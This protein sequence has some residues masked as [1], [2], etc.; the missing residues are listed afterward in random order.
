MQSEVNSGTSGAKQ[1]V[2]VMGAE[3]PEG[4]HYFQPTRNSPELGAWLN[5]QRWQGTKGGVT[6]EEARQALQPQSPE[7]KGREDKASGWA[8]V[9]GWGRGQC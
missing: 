2:R 1:L 4:V 3:S 5:L 8:G 9:R 7:T 6:E